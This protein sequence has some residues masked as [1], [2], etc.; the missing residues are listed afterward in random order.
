MGDREEGQ[1]CKCKNAKNTKM[2]KFLTEMTEMQK[3][4]YL[5]SKKSFLD[6]IKSMFHNYLSAI[7]WWKKWKIADTNFNNNKFPNKD[8]IHQIII[9]LFLSTILFLLLEKGF[10]K[11]Y[12]Q[13]YKWMHIK[14]TCKKRI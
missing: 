6:E 13:K 7:S 12:L 3:F 1:K 9:L 10:S 11:S 8:T 14:E 4:E 5:R 2:Q